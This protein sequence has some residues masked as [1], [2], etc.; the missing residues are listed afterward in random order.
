MRGLWFLLVLGVCGLSGCGGGDSGSSSPSHVQSVAISPGKGQSVSENG[1]LNLTANVLPDLNQ[2]VVWSLSGPGS[3]TLETPSSV[4]FTAP[5]NISTPTYTVVIA[6]SAGD[7]SV[8]S[9]LPLTVMPLGSF[10]NVQP[11][12]VDGGP[13]PG[14]VYPNGGF[15]SVTVCVPGTVTCKTID[16]I[17]VD[18]GSSGLRVL[19]SALPALPGLT[20]SGS[21]TVAECVQFPDTSYLW[22]NVAIADVRISGEVAGSIS[23]HAIADQ[24]GPAVPTDCSSN[25][26]GINANSQQALG[27][28]GILGVGLEPQDCGAVCDPSAGGQPPPSAY[29]TCSG[30]SCSPTFVPVL[31]QVTH[32]ALLFAK[33]NNGVSLQFS[34]VP[35]TAAALSGSLTFGI[36]TQANNTLGDATVFTLTPADNFTTKVVST[37]QTLTPSFIDSGLIANFFPDD[38]LPACAAPR[39]RLFC[40]ASTTA[41]EAVNTGTNNAQ[42]SINFSV[43]NADNLFTTNPTNAAFSTLAGP[44]GSGFEWGLPFFYGRT[45]F[46]SI[47]GQAVPAPAP[48]APWW[49]YTIGFSQ[50]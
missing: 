34:A 10:A 17:L 23:I 29:Y 35:G 9:Y 38:S 46:T 48:A 36:G 44:S 33:D 14:Q 2:G 12:N 6:T 42:S 5:S 40:P 16:G 37:G 1:V 28:N 47:D 43:D 31:Q 4:T 32:P 24:G 39:S 3:L 22:G 27:A 50:P 8:S 26:A 20:A 7:S 21:S 30:T 19:A 13:V 45:V 25:G 41:L 11:V 18:T 49:A 15:T